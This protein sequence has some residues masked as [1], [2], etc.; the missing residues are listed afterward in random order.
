MVF[1]FIF[2]DLFIKLGI[3]ITKAITEENIRINGKA[4]HPNQTLKQIEFSIT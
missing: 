2:L 4:I 3:A 1:G